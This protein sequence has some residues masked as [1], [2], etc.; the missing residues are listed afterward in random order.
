MR[1]WWGTL[2]RTQRIVGSVVAI[3]VAV[4]VVLASLGDVVPR[5]PGGPSSSSFATAPDGLAAYVEHGFEQAPDGSVTLRCRPEVEAATFENGPRHHT[6]D[7]LGEI[8]TPTTVARGSDATPG[9]AS[10]ALYIVER[11]PNAT[12]EDHPDLGHFGPLQDPPAIARS[13]MDAAAPDTRQA[14]PPS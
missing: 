13:I 12:L 5:S 3:V 4:N 8:T 7:R 10:M 9:P 14:G 11:L 1:A 6:F 2:G